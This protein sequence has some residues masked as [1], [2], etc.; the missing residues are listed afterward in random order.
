M[1]RHLSVLVLCFVL[2]IYLGGF[3]PHQLC[4]FYGKFLVCLQNYYYY[5]YKSLGLERDDTL[6][7]ISRDF[8]M[9]SCLMNATM[10]FSS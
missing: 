8:S 1:L 3:L 7:W 5:P 2:D 4:F 10:R 6:M 9:A